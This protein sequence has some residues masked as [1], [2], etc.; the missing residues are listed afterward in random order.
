MRNCIYEEKI[1]RFILKYRDEIVENVCRFVQIPSVASERE[2]NYPYGRECAKAL[3]FC[4]RLA[5]EKGLLVENYDY[6]GMEIRPWEV[7]GGK[8]LLLA[9]H[10][11]VVPESEGNLYPAF[12]G[13]VDK[14][15]IIGRGVVDDKAPL[16]AFLYALIFLK[17]ENIHPK[18]DVRL[19]A[20]SHEETDMEDIRYYL[21]RAGQPDFGLA[22]DDDFP[23][24]NGEKSVLK[25]RLSSENACKELWDRL[26]R[27]KNGEDFGICPENGRYGNFICR[28]KRENEKSLTADMRLPVNLAL[29]EVKQKIESFAKREHL[30]VEFQKEDPGY[31]ISENEEI[32][33]LLI[34]LYNKVSGTEDKAYVMAG[35]T[36]ARHFRRGCGFGAGNPREVKPFPKGHG[37]AHGADEAQNI[38]VLMHAL[39]M[40]ILAILAIDAYWNKIKTD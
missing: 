31:Y 33:K 40:D 6:Y 14:G 9:A 5:V 22:A 10:A 13:V 29:E 11:D 19:F 18:C 36:Y 24:T 20:G 12:G 27:D 4:A 2:G 25:F 30:S 26:E 8:R 17:E 1:E 23:I 28:M 3:E 21:A 32:P 35:C 15:Y 34:D 37:G 38:E 39:K 7:S 16:I